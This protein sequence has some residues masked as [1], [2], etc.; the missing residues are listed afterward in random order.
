MGE[1]L[2][3]DE[4]VDLLVSDV[5]EGMVPLEVDLEDARSLEQPYGDE[6]SVHFEQEIVTGTSLRASSWAPS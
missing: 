5:F 4:L 1:E 6:L 3:G 2:P